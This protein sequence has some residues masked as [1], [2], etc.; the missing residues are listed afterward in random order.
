MQVTL[1][2]D[3]LDIREEDYYTSLYNESQAQFN[4]YARLFSTYFRNNLL[5]ILFSL[6][7]ETFSFLQVEC[8]T[9]WVSFVHY[10]FFEKLYILVVGMFRLEQ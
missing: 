7:W 4:T 9:L 8:E 6:E 1:R 2:R 10:M 5:F 3:S